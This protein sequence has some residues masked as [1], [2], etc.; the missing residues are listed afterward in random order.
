MATLLPWNFFISV[1]SF[2]DYKFRAVNNVTTA[3]EDIFNAEEQ[4]ELQREFTSY[5]AIAS[6]I[7]NA[8]CV[9]LNAVLGQKI[10][11]KFRLLGSLSAVITLFFLVTIFSKADSDTWQEEFLELVLCLVVLINCFT[12]VFQVTRTIAVLWYM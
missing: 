7:P 2:W 1:S 8:V 12:A 9:I 5:L 11:L 3:N 6:N 4:T 10:K